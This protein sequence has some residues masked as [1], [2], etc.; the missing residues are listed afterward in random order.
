MACNVIIHF[1]RYYHRISTECWFTHKH[2]CTVV[3]S[4]RVWH[5]RTIVQLHRMTIST[6]GA[7]T[8]QY[9]HKHVICCG[10]SGHSVRLSAVFFFYFANVCVCVCVLVMWRLCKHTCE[11]VSTCCSTRLYIWLWYMALFGSK[12]K[13]YHRRDIHHAILYTFSCWSGGITI[14]SIAHYIDTT[15]IVH[16][17]VPKIILA[18]SSF[19]VVVCL[20]CHWLAGCG[21][22]TAT[23]FTHGANN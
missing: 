23:R 19:R 21:R 20:C 18:A 6:N 22:L 5:Y 9:A 15:A 3:G 16:W 4:G 14:I 12:P 11:F 17:C 13:Q 10:F 1:I 2:V 8:S 7:R